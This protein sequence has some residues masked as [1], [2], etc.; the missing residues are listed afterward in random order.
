MKKLKILGLVTFAI[1][2]LLYAAAQEVIPETNPEEFKGFYLGGTVST[3]GWGGEVKYIFNKRFTV[4][5]GY[6]TLNLTQNIDYTQDDIDFETNF[7][8]KTGSVFLLGDLFYTRNLYLSGG[9]MFNSFNPEITGYASSDMQYGDI[10]IPASDV[11]DFTITVTPELKISPYAALG[12][13]S[14][15]GKKKMVMWTTEIGC[16]YMGAPQV[17]I[18]ASGLA[19]PTADPAHG[20]KESLEYQIEQ[21]KFYPVLK[22][23]LAVKLF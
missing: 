14:F 4:R 6:E 10:I 5:T 17:D 2:Q 1:F 16:F 7:D 9:V 12:V 8:Y 15:F 22:M 11:G 3:N 20:Q 23:G 13:R 18:E 21:Y 19:A